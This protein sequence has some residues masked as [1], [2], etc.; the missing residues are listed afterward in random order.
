V[1]YY[2]N[3]DKVTGRIKSSGMCSTEADVDLNKRKGFE[4]VKGIF[5]NETSKKIETHVDG[6]IIYRVA[7]DKT[8]EEIEAQKKPAISFEKQKANITNEQLQSIM[9]RLEKLESEV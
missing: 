5:A 4:Q 7:V 6:M 9:D 1:F 2:T 3:Y 8:P